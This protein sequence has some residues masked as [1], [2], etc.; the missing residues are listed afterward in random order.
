MP[1]AAE[2][3]SSVSDVVVAGLL[4]QMA[5]GD[6]K[7][8]DRLPGERQLAEDFAV[9]RVSVR[10]AL[11]QLKA[12]GFLT[13]VQGGG[14]HVASDAGGA[15][16]AL[17]ELVRTDRQG[18]G[19]LVELRGMLEAWAAERAARNAKADD[20]AILN[21]LV[22]R[23]ADAPQAEQG[24]LDTEFHLAIAKASGSL[25]YRHLLQ[26]IRATLAEMLEFHRVELFGTKEGDAAILAQH[27]AIVQAIAQRSPIHARA[28]MQAHL[29]WVRRHYR[30]PEAG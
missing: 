17:A 4:R 30:E 8:G 20:I 11:Q 1:Q 14:T 29:D 12:Q 25:V 5:A 2:K 21:A 15:S 16:P 3:R 6:L 26:L 27:R 24:G 19:D 9:S 18:F 10:A 13:A 28:A 23:M 22:A 7:P